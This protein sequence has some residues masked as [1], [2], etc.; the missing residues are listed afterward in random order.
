VFTT[1]ACNA[2][3]MHSTI[4]YRTAGSDQHCQVFCLVLETR[5]TIQKW[6][7]FPSKSIIN[8]YGYLHIVSHHYTSPFSSNNQK[9]RKQ[10]NTEAAALW[11]KIFQC[12]RRMLNWPQGSL[13][14]N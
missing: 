2:T 14:F 11:K 3:F 7:D 4:Q 6:W 10:I 8:N 12:N 5:A 9:Y 13:L 1:L